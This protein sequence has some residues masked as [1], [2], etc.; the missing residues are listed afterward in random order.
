[1]SELPR[2]GGWLI[3]VS[4]L[5]AFALMILPMPVA[6]EGLRPQWVALLTLYWCLAV[7]ERFG[8]FAAFGTGLALDVIS[9]A[10]L[11]QHALGLSLIGYAAVALH[12]RVRLF[13]IWQQTLFVWALLLVER[14]INVWILAATAQPL[15][16]LDYWL[17]TLLGVLLWPWLFVIM[18]DL[19]RRAGLIL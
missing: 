5:I 7:P 11:G 17:A 18:S 6:A 16:G 4:L 14:V 10:L 12:Q 2:R 9:G 8:V 13:P 3:L 1:M 15:P 19:G